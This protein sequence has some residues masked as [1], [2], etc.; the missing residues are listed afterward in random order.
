MDAKQA[1][2]T[3][4]V[5]PKKFAL[6]RFYVRTTRVNEITD[7]LSVNDYV[8]L[9]IASAS[10]GP[11]LEAIIQPE[12]EVEQ[13]HDEDTQEHVIERK[14]NGKGKIERAPTAYN[15]FIKNTCEELIKTHASLTP[16]ERY[17]LAIQMW[18]DRKGKKSGGSGACAKP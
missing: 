1:I 13:V 17:A 12:S 11:K 5:K 8:A 16:R 18:N 6:P 4:D 7:E 10:S 3:Q 14:A 15:M 2:T 9:N